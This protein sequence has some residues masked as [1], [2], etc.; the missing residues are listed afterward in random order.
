[1]REEEKRSEKTIDPSLWLNR[2]FLKT[3]VRKYEQVQKQEVRAAYGYLEGW[4]S[5]VVNVLLFGL[6]LFIGLF[7][8]S[9]S[10]IA[11][12]F[13]TLSDVLTSIV[14]LLGFRLSRR[15]PDEKHPYGHGRFENI[16]TLV[17][18]IL[19]VIVGAQF[20]WS[21]LQRLIEPQPVR[22]TIVVVMTILFSALVKEWLARFAIHLGQKIK[23]SVLLADAWHH[24]SD[25]IAALLVS[26]AIF[27]AMFGYI[28]V[29]SIFGMLVSGLIIYTGFEFGR[30]ATSFLIGEAPDEQMI[31]EIR[32]VARSI[33]GVED[34]HEITIHDYGNH[35]AVL[36]HVEVDKTL[37]VRESHEIATK[38]QSKISSSLD[39]VTA[40]VHIE[41]AEKAEARR[42]KP[43]QK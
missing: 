40:E 32:D 1:M 6:K 39:D 24:R 17:I 21:S 26:V 8:N 5:I 29:D 10:L 27:A 38:V 33:D 20:F 36:L 22:G 19:L 14:V 7:I 37:S 16:A 28:Q 11:D 4:V 43:D 13:H 9:I 3:F 25:A 35:K 2:F 42:K 34:T 41:P 15:P 30:S 31:N 23:A 18:A 12:S